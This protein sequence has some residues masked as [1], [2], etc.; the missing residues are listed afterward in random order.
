MILSLTILVG[1][2]VAEGSRTAAAAGAELALR[3]LEESERIVE[4]RASLEE[5]TRELELAKPP[6]EP[7]K[8][9]AGP[10]PIATAA[11]QE[12][13]PTT[14]AELRVQPL[15]DTF[16]HLYGLS[17]PSGG[18]PILPG[19]RERPDSGGGQDPVLHP[20]YFLARIFPGVGY[21]ERFLVHAPLDRSTPRPMLVVFHKY[22]VGYLDALANTHFVQEGMR[23]QWYVVCPLSASGVN[24][25]SI[26]SQVNT[27][28][29]LDW[30]VSNPDL[31]VDTSRVYGVGFSMG[32][33]SV[34]N[35]AARH[36]DPG[37]VM[38]A[39]VVNHT[40]G[41]AL[42]DSYANAG[43][44]EFVFD[45]WFGDGSQGSADP[46]KLA[47]SS[48]LNFDPVTLAVEDGEDLARNLLHVP[49]WIVRGQQDPLAYLATQC[50]VLYGHMLSL[51][52]VPGV[53]I[54]Y[55]VVPGTE[56]E[57]ATL[58]EAD[59]C[60]W[61]EQFTL[62]LPTSGRTLAD[63]DETYFHFAV[64]QDAPDAFT[65]FEWS[66]DALQNQLVLS[67]TAN[68]ARVTVDTQEAALDP[69]ATLQVVTS[70]GDGLA[71][72]ISLTGYATQPSAVLRDGLSVTL[73]VDW[74]W[75]STT[76]TV[77]LLETDGSTRHVWDVLP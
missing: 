8:P 59:A 41:V 6:R 51:G 63:E 20:Q 64:E 27:E 29:V 5:P 56:H 66:A 7:E 19:I 54:R 76:G 61:L 24:F 14:L 2:L 45:F 46:W 77:G 39:A 12:P 70:T 73:D 13:R 50:D 75:D 42:K 69:S 22:N 36:V 28:A 37:G 47:R 21:P 74:T 15:G 52:A 17:A 65:P 72:E 16:D 35:Y 32:G 55:D 3:A 18:G 53:T 25:S 26:E 33:G 67:Q 9:V 49:M 60:D 71:D 40:G 58:D 62:Q 11:P 57:W 43:A 23:R 34:T 1:T 10:L 38:F 31:N 68:L 48:I 30:M 4:E 44:A